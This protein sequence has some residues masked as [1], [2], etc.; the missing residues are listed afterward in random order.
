MFCAP[1]LNI[2]FEVLAVNN[3]VF[4]IDQSPP[5]FT[6]ALGLKVP[7]TTVKSLFTSSKSV[8]DTTPSVPPSL[9]SIVKL[10]N[11]CP[12]EAIVTLPK[13]FV[14]VTVP[15]FPGLNVPA[16]IHD[17]ATA[18]FEVLPS[19]TVKVAKPFVPSSG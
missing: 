1:P 11:D 14:K 13:G 4:C 6:S 18:I 7:S 19:C 16:L 12:P 10:L 8:F 17:P 5:I 15:E 3:P 2:T 9:S